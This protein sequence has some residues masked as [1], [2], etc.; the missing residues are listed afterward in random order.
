M[1]PASPP[2]DVA[3][4]GITNQRETTV[5]WD[6]Q[7]GRADPQGHRL[8]GPPHRAAAA[9]SS[10]PT[11]WSNDPRSSTGL[12]VDA[13]FSGTKVAW[14]LDNVAGARGPPSVA[15]S[16]SAPST[17]FLLWRLTDGAV[18]AT[19]ATN[20]S[21]TMLFDIGRM[22]WDEELLRCLR[23]PRR[24]CCRRSSTTAASSARPGAARC[25]DPDRRH[26]RR[27]A[28]GDLFGQA[29][30]TPGMLQEHLR[31]RLLRAAQH[32][33]AHGALA[34]PAAHH[35]RLAR[36]AASRPT[37]SRAASSSPA[38]PSSGCATACGSSAVPPRPR[39]CAQRRSPT[40][41]ASTSSPRSPASAPRGGIPTPA[42]PS[43]A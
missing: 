5:V 34:Q 1:A 11:A 2:T 9:A 25:R 39:P 18:H 19:D 13:Y 35:D 24:R 12:V 16:P 15:A 38:P 4:I 23:H 21:R 31:H 30:F 37:R 20:A 28:G 33:R 32:R 40:P 6:R 43:S 27:P 29:C 36:S 26:R 3:A 17:R 14:L 8:A 22:A 10:S 41:T 7:T 42:A